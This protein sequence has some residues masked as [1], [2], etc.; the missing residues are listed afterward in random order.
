[1]FNKFFFLFITFC[2][3][4]IFLLIDEELYIDIQLFVWKIIQTKQ[5]FWFIALIVY[6]L[7]SFFYWCFLIKYHSEHF[8]Y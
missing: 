8:I 2:V 4:L 1:M 7:L 5:F 3:L 6:M